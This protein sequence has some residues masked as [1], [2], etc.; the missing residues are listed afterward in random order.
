MV[1]AQSEMQ[2]MIMS[3]DILP[4]SILE[5]VFLSNFEKVSSVIST[6]N[7]YEKTSYGW[8]V[9][10]IAAFNNDITMMKYLLK[11][12]HMNDRA[13]HLNLK[14]CRGEIKNIK[15]ITGMTSLHVAIIMN[16]YEIVKVLIEE[17]TPFQ[18]RDNCG[19]KPFDYCKND[20]IAV[21][22]VEYELRGYESESTKIQWISESFS[23]S[24]EEAN[25]E[26][27][28]DST[29]VVIDQHD[30]SVADNRPMASSWHTLCSII[31]NFQF[32]V[33][34]TQF[35]RP[36]IDKADANGDTMLHKTTTSGCDEAFEK[37]LKKGANIY[38]Y[39]NDYDLP[40][41]KS[42]ETRAKHQQIDEIIKHI[43]LQDRR[44]L[45]KIFVCLCIAFVILNTITSLMLKLE[46]PE[47]G[48]MQYFIILWTTFS[49]VIL[50]NFVLK[51]VKV[52]I[53][54]FF[55][56]E[57]FSIFIYL[58]I[59]P[60]L[61]VV[62]VAD[63]KNH[64]SSLIINLTFI[65][66]INAFVLCWVEFCNQSTHANFQKTPFLH[67]ARVLGLLS[68]YFVLIY[69]GGMIQGDAVGVSK[70]GAAFCTF[71]AKTSIISFILSIFSMI[72]YVMCL[73]QLMLLYE[74]SLYN[75]LSK[76]SQSKKHIRS[77]KALF[78]FCILSL[79]MFDLILT[80]IMLAF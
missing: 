54:H 8:T 30:E 64:L 35:F 47:H 19:N 65:Y 23:R 57:H 49:L 77:R 28:S 68:A 72:I 14:Y 78:S 17:G 21:Q 71:S 52:N 15:D 67:C 75:S 56:K 27:V 38:I 13:K 20:K 73:P 16:C 59:S 2:R 45:F 22:L 69:A 39:N 5:A 4:G 70:I 36:Q 3:F 24:I 41:H 32:F 76:K 25:S 18:N 34:T 40:L 29:V 31:F 63:V 62:S 11:E 43:A 37:L 1:S 33:F 50:F 46:S 42:A 60:M 79:F 12:I 58:L 44:N 66:L 26:H 53:R 10:H 48:P 9:F 74:L 7:I 80:L 6:K 61:I 55:F 51:S